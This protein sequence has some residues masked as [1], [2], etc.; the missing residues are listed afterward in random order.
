MAARFVWSCYKE[1]VCTKYENVADIG[2]TILLPQF[3]QDCIFELIQ[4][5]KET[6]MSEKPVQYIDGDVIIIGDIHGNIIDL[7]RIMIKCG[8]PPYQRYVFLGDYVDR[9]D[10][11]LDVI[12]FLFS[13]KVIFPLDVTLLRGNHEFPQINKKYGFYDNIIDKFNNPTLW[14]EFNESFRYLPICCILSHTYF[15]VHGGISERINLTDL[16]HLHYPIDDSYLIEVLVWSD[17]TDMISSTFENKRGKG[18]QYG[19]MTTY[20]FLHSIQCKGIIRAHECVDGFRFSVDNRVITIFSSSNYSTDN[21]NCGYGVFHEEKL[22]CFKLPLVPK[23]SVNDINYF[24]AVYK[25]KDNPRLKASLSC[26]CINLSKNSMAEINM[27]PQFTN[28]KLLLPK[29][30]VTMHFIPVRCQKSKSLVV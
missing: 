7:F 6:L 30:R 4:E 19:Y 10:M 16:E 3:Q 23:K 9:G 25:G 14:A 29:P 21:N 13:M 2:D 8:F 22:E 27:R 24:S 26:H 1:I 17:P 12:T 20:K 18:L 11:S 5:T 28:N 15:C